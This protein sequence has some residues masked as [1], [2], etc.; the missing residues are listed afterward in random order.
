MPAHAH[1]VGVRHLD[2][3]GQKLR[4]ERT[5]DFDLNVAEL[6][7]VIDCGF[8]FF[9]GIGKNFGGT[10]IRTAAVNESGHHHA[11]A[12][13]GT[14]VETAAH[15]HEEISIVGQVA[16]RS[17]AACHVQK[18]IAGRNMNMHV[19]EPGHQGFAGGVNGLSVFGERHLS[20]CAHGSD[21]VSGDHHGAVG[22]HCAD[23]ESN[24]L[25]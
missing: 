20:V 5:I 16:D 9:F 10:L 14:S 19:P 25:A 4:F 17:Y 2:N 24:K 11:R 1:A 13:F 7:V 3:L 23:W 12:D 15:L 22:E 21:V 6:G 18:T 8:G